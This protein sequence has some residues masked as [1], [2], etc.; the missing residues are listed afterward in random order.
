MSVLFSED[1]VFGPKGSSTRPQFP[2]LCY[3]VPSGLQMPSPTSMKC[4][5]DIS[6]LPVRGLLGKLKNQSWNS[7]S[8]GAG[9][10]IFIVS[11]FNR[12]LVFEL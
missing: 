4:P 2:Q 7:S 6:D 5:G 11:L 12:C 8:A 3:G 1:D 10:S 9:L